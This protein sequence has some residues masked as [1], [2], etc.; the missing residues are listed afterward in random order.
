M[1]STKASRLAEHLEDYRSLLE[2]SMILLRV[3]DHEEADALIEE[4]G[5]LIVE[6]QKQ[7]RHVAECRLHG[8]PLRIGDVVFHKE[9]QAW[10]VVTS[11]EERVDVIENAEKYKWGLDIEEQK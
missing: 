6:F 4:L 9:F 2:Q 8:R 3:K 1:K 10:R 7:A 11:D 5:D